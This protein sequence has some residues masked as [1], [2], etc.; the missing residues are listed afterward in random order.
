MDCVF[1]DKNDLGIDGIEVISV[2]DLYENIKN[3]TTQKI[4][5]ISCA[6]SLGFMDGG[7]D[8]GYM[9]CL[10][11]IQDRVQKGIKILNKKSQLGRPFL[12]IGDN[13]GFWLEENPN[14][15][16]VCT[17]TMFL[18]QN[19]AGSDNQYIC[20]KSALQLCK[21][22]G[23]EKVYTPMMCTGWG[24]YKPADAYKLMS[25]AVEDYNKCLPETVFSIGKY[26]YNIQNE[27]IK[28]EILKK[29]PKV[30][31][32]MEFGITVEQLLET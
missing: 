21:L 24:G 31:M 13:M 4:A 17:P 22:M 11:G 19:V 28:K 2:E 23:I 15:F 16:F 18:P 8:L 32:N 1:F 5:L 6:N 14:I 29:Q 7:S 20:L 26:T 30:Y 25:H 12:Y 10:D 3:T 27:Y 9:N